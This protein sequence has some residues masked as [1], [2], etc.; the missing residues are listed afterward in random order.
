RFLT[1][2]TL[3]ASS[4]LLRAADQATILIV[5]SATVASGT[6]P[7]GTAPDAT[8]QTIKVV[9]GTAA[10]NTVMVP[11]TNITE[12]TGPV[13]MCS[14]D[15]AKECRTEATQ[16]MSGC[17]ESCNDHLKEYGTENYFECFSQNNA[18][19]TEAEQCLFGEMKNYCTSVPTETRFIAHADWA[20]L[21]N[22]KY[23]SEANK[24]IKDNFLWKRE[25]AK[26]TKL[27]NFLHCT[28]H[29]MHNK[30]SKCTKAKGCG[31]RMP[32]LAEFAKNM[33]ACTKKNTKIATSLLT[34]CQCLAWKKG[35]TELRGACGV[36]GS[37]Y[38]VDRA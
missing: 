12:V 15:E 32:K 25:E 1:V 22:F 31:V 24:E 36:V 14:C 13:R 27:Q 8:A 33:I 17:M 37:Q 5:E 23:A 10:P 20:K 28:K 9:Y 35:V 19:I 16:G 34:T 11:G 29:C 26:F 7:A 21:T 18:S 30:I 2:F 3:C 6:V 38:Y 4:V